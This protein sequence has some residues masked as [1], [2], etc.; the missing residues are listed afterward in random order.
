[1]FD[2]DII[3][4]EAFAADLLLRA[5]SAGIRVQRDGDRLLMDGAEYHPELGC[6]LL[7]HRDVV[8]RHWWAV[9]AH[10]HLAGDSLGQKLM[11]L[12]TVTAHAEQ[13]RGLPREEAE[14][15]A[16]GLLVTLEAI[17]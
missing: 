3:D 9:Q 12:F 15:I 1:M 5:H 10:F 2:F 6:E 7:C 11:E 16:F 17:E 13:R 14:Q 4:H 8:C